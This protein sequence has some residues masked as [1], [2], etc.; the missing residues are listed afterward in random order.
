MIIG[1]FDVPENIPWKNKTTFFKVW[2]F[3][4]WWIRVKSIGCDP[5][6][7]EVFFFFL[8]AC[9][10]IVVDSFNK[11]ESAQQRKQQLARESFLGFELLDEPR[12]R[13]SSPKNDR[14]ATFRV[15]DTVL[16]I[17]L[18]KSWLLHKSIFA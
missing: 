11:W 13:K 8:N 18:E 2:I 1:I 6:I 14:N 10:M 16:P 17:Q 3:D 9:E 7:H 4:E 15:G 5:N 12:W